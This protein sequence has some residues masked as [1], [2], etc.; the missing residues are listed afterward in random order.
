MSRSDDR[1]A[2]D[3]GLWLAGESA[4]GAADRAV[5]ALAHAPEVRRAAGAALA[6]EDL[7]RDWYGGLPLAP[8]P[9]HEVARR[10]RRALASAWLAAVATG[11]AVVALTGGERRALGRALDA[12][13]S[14][15]S[16]GPR[17]PADA[18]S[19]WRLRRDVDGL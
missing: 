10:H 16:T 14:W 3:I 11:L 17:T 7:V 19:W 1:L 13:A 5:A 8:A 15:L 4:G 2:R 18:S 6:V 9:P 12:T